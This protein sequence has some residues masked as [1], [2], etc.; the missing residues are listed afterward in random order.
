M[1]VVIE[2][3]GMKFG[4]FE[5]ENI[6]YIERSNIYKQ[7]QHG[8]QMA[9]F[10]LFRPEKKDLIILEAKTTAPN[11]NSSNMENEN[12]IDDRRKRFEE[13]ITEIHEKVWLQDIQDKL[14]QKLR[15]AT[16]TWLCTVTVINEEDARKYKLIQ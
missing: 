11:P 8:V 7:L 10:L 9:E 5:E 3:S 1:S 14:Q 16:K 4:P 2:E 6:F 15:V 13:Y 12:Q